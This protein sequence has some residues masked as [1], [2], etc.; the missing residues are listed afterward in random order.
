MQFIDANV[1]LRFLTRD[2]LAK[3]E[4]VKALLEQAE[5]GEVELTTS[6]SVICELVFVLSSPRLY[7]LNRERVRLLLLPLVSL[8]GLKLLSRT[9]FLRALDLYA[10]TS[11][12]FVDALVVAHMEARKVTELYSYDKHFDGVS[13]IRRLEP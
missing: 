2:D 11:M 1:F 3:A 10:G 12:D 4:R 7:N 5:Q 13:G 9:V 6:E 8:R